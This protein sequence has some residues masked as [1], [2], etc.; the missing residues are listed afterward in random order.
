MDNQSLIAQLKMRDQQ[1]GQ[2]SKKA[3]FQEAVVKY[4]HMKIEELGQD[5]VKDGA[6]QKKTCQ[7]VFTNNLGYVIWLLQHQPENPKFANIL[8]YARRVQTAS[9]TEEKGGYQ[10]KKKATT[11]QQVMVPS[12]PKPREIS[13]GEPTPS[14]VDSEWSAVNLLSQG[15]M[16]VENQPQQAEMMDMMKSMVMGFQDMNNRLQALS[17]TTENQQ[18]AIHQTYSVIMQMQ[19]TQQ[20][21]AERLMEF[22]NHVKNPK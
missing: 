12:I 9:S 14:E 11:P 10:D 17:Q 22:E 18:G 7:E 2:D 4:R 19:E 16:P 8:E 1:Q 5:L 6:H 20:N 15:P 3:A 21:H 13:G